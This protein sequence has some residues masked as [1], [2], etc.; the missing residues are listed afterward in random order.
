MA[1]RLY[2]PGY[3]MPE[4]STPPRR[5]SICWIRVYGADRSN[6]S[7]ERVTWMPPAVSNSVRPSTCVSTGDPLPRPAPGERMKRPPLPGGRFWNMGA[8]RSQEPPSGGA[9]TARS[10]RFACG[11]LS[12]PRP[13]PPASR[14]NRAVSALRGRA[15]TGR[16]AAV[17]PRPAVSWDVAVAAVRWVGRGRLARRGHCDPGR[18]DLLHDRLVLRRGQAQQLV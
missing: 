8:T 13:G 3:S 4:L 1:H 9:T 7:A 15:I 12:R 5:P 17:R 14:V 16:L 2:R 10:C 6:A 11:E 18:R